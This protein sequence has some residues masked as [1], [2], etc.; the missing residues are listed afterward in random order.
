MGSTH[1]YDKNTQL[2]PGGNSDTRPLE[3]RVEGGLT[4][5]FRNQRKVGFCFI[6]IYTVRLPGWLN[7]LFFQC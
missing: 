3:P 4:G 6:Q 5:V 1:I 7:A 2:I